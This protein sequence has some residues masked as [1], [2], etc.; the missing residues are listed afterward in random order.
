MTQSSITHD[1][2]GLRSL[3]GLTFAKA[4][5]DWGRAGAGVRGPLL[6]V[7]AAVTLDVLAR[8]GV[9]HIYP[10]PVLLL[11]VICAA[12]WG[13]LWPALVSTVV[14]TV[15]AVH[16]FSQTR[17]AL[18]YT[19]S[20]MTGL[21]VVGA[22]SSIAAL[23][24]SRLRTKASRGEE[25]ALTRKEAE[26]L[27]R[28]L[29]FLEQVGE[30]LASSLEYEHT[31]RDLAR[32]MV[33]GLADWCTI[34]LAAEQGM[35]QFVAGAHRDPARDL[36][37]R[38]LC[39]YGVRA[40]PFG[41]PGATSD[42]T[43]VGEVLLRQRAEDAEHLKLYRALAP[44]SVLRVPLHARGRTLGVLTLVI[45]DE[46]GRRFEVEDLKFAEELAAR[47]ALA[48]DNAHLYRE[49]VEADR[50]YRLLFDANPQPMWVFD[51]ETLVFLAVNDAAVRHYGYSRDELLR[52]SIMD[53]LP[54][55][56]TPGLTAS[57]E[58]GHQ[59][60]GVA[61][62]QHQRKD[63]SI[64]DMEIVS[65]AL[66]VDGHKA[67]LVLATDITERTR[68]RAALHQSEEQLRHAQR[69][70]AVGR[71]A[72]GVAHDFNNILTTVRGFGEIL[73]RDLDP[74]DHRRAD[75]DR[76]CKAADRGALLTRQL[77]AFG[78][79]QTL[80]PRPTSLN[81]L[82]RGMQGFM[83]RL[84]GADIR[85][86]MRLVSGAA[87]VR[88]D[89]GQLEQ[90]VVNLILNARDAMPSGGAL[91]IETS[92]RQISRTGRGRHVRPGRYVVL[93]ISDTG[94]GLDPDILA[95]PFEVFPGTSARGQRAGLGLSIVYG[96]VRQNGG[97]VRVASEPDQGTT[98]KLYLPLHDE[99]DEPE[100]A[101]EERSLAG[102]ETVLVVEDEDAVRELLRKV[103]DE[104]GYT[105]LEA[106]DGRDA[107]LLAERY[108][109]PIHLVVTDVVM[110][111]MG[112]RELVAA[113][114]PLYPDVSVLYISGY[115]ND[116]VLRRGV[117]DVEL[118][119]KPFSPG[120]LL[121]KVRELLDAATR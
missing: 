103:L 99:D 13:G 43:E 70:D 118:I 72:S 33:S 68:T 94:S 32:L 55:E 7:A 83:Q 79:R 61:L 4:A 82:L 63:G 109:Q 100:P 114:T 108:Q 42:L 29:S 57:L 64:I 1:T 80:Q 35:L 98:V 17:P 2:N 30:R 91:T 40:L 26:A 106:R 53:I 15:Y 24:V 81:E 107:L 69:M 58:R 113:L 115:T 8:Q 117:S 112:G 28:R 96:I 36:V 39:E 59:R 67:R 25:I 97:A 93:A 48:V 31:L 22:T 66:E 37:V 10:F 121:R 110:P 105:V 21:L 86:S 23:V 74:E 49:A 120:D 52:M 92:E 11:T 84:V 34:H 38:A 12:Y 75:V 104:H 62:A 90:L 5:A 71:I 56:D 51:V 87:K 9:A 54:P 47:S 73:L 3:A 77:L 111:E 101:G 85:V 27:D 119:H 14:T 78:R 20:G 44:R 46:S 60:E 88:M 16:F 19:P 6:T 65:H 116:E 102:T 18:H 41:E 89:P 76:I 45:G 95:H 50:R